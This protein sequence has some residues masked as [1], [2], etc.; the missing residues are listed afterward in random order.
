MTALLILLFLL[1]LWFGLTAALAAIAELTQPRETK[2]ERMVARVIEFSR[3][4]R[5]A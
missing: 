1:A 2:Q 4:R 5:A 3:G